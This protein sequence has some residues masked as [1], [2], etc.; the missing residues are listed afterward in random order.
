MSS[1]HHHSPS[2]DVPS[3][4]M[5][6]AAPLLWAGNAVV[7]HMAQ[8]LISPFALNLLRWTIALI[9]LLP[10]GW[11]ALSR[12]GALV[13]LWPYWTVVGL[14]G[15]GC[16]N[17]LLYLALETSSPL[18]VTLVSSSMP[19]WM[20][21]LGRIFWGVAV[22]PRQIGGA[23]LS[24]LGVAVVLS[25]GQWAVLQ[26][27]QLVPGDFFILLATI[28]WTVYTW[29]LTRYKG[30]QELKSHWAAFL[31]AQ[32]IFG[33]VWTIL[34]GVLEFGLGR[35]YIQ[36]NWQLAAILIFIAV[37]PAVLAYRF[38]GAGVARTSPAI[39]GFFANL[40]PLFTAILSIIIL[41]QKPSLYHAV[42]FILI[43]GGIVISSRK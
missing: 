7:G 24:M 8:A 5:L 30:S 25:R 20:L 32:V 21:A 6:S 14:L 2:L 18:N 1:R 28:L 37:G 10:L 40:I 12:S 3:A 23:I 19:I 35:F 16:Y 43:V 41:G 4:L 33:M 26:N 31:L 13:R 15:I 27:M 39:A 38:W 36:L 22:T 42:A 11:A 9:V 17:G 34:F 29:L